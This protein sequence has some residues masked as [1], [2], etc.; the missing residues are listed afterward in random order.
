MATIKF[1]RGLAAVL[2]EKNPILKE[3]EP[4]VEMDTG[5]LKIGNGILPWNQLGYLSGEGAPGSS[6][7]SAYELAVQQGY[8]G[9]LSQ[10]LTSLH[11]AAGS[12]GPQG[13]PGLTGPKGDTGN[14][15]P[16]GIQGPKGDTGD[17]GPQ[18]I[19]GP[20]GDTGAAGASYTGPKITASSSAPASPTTGDVW[21]DTSS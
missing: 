13:E 5:K 16:Q 4:C 6:G 17:V 1:R 7:K 18:G 14:T 2:S 10:W 20:K 9:T 8:S 12:P 19:Q 11:G 21:I 3:G 15:G